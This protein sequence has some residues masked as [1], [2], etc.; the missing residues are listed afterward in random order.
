M[1]CREQ[2]DQD[3][4][5]LGMFPHILQTLL[6]HAVEAGRLVKGDERRHFSDQDLRAQSRS[7]GEFLGMFTNGCLKAHMFED[8][9]MQLMC[10]LLKICG[11]LL[12][13]L[14]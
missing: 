12:R 10:Q 8:R 13:H 4:G 14:G 9:W 6:Q 7:C 11:E 5:G 3:A 2:S 1:S